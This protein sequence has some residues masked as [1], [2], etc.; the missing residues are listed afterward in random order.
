METI[1]KFTV[2]SLT[3]LLLIGLLEVNS[4]AVEPSAGATAP[5]GL[6][7]KQEYMADS[8]CHQKLPAIQESSLAGDHPLL[9]S[10]ETIDFYGPC[11]QDP[12]GN[13]QLNAQRLE[14]SDRK[15]K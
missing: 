13:D 7:L 8:Y 3:A 12:M 5:K 15:S 6:L 10:E 2:S 11:N 4:N 14:S 9:S 1:T